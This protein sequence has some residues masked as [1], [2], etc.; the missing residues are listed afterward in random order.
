MSIIKEDIESEDENDLSINKLKQLF[1]EI[2]KNKKLSL[3]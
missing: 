1:F 2:T 3:I